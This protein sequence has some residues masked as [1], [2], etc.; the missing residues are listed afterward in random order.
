MPR[1]EHARIVE[2]LVA[3]SRSSDLL[4]VVKS[5]KIPLGMFADVVRLSRCPVVLWFMDS[6]ANV[7][8]GL[9]RAKLASFLFYYEGSDGQVFKDAGVRARPMDLAADMRWYRPL[10][11]VQRY[12]F[13][14]IGTFYENRLDLLEY[15]SSALA[16]HRIVVKGQYVA[17]LRPWT[18]LA[19][20]KQYPHLFKVV[21]H[22]QMASHEQINVLNNASKI[23][24]NMMR[25]GS[26]DSLNMRV[27]ELCASG[28]FQ[29]VGR[30]PAL[31]R[32]FDVGK[33]V[34]VFSSKEEAADKTRYYL[35]NEKARV[36][37]AKN[38]RQR[39]AECHSM[40]VRTREMLDTLQ[41]EGVLG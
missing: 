20:K 23:G 15:L 36:E 12:D 13:S 19:F 2:R 29:L 32:C 22:V 16:G 24:L 37:I 17:A 4:F 18:V 26:I 10:N 27:F 25:N 33:E 3:S 38:G 1:M 41:R 14:F 39:V 34:E 30:C 8:E 5:D 28:A 9:D 35:R 31:E 21:R 7:R 6:Y 11:S 40:R